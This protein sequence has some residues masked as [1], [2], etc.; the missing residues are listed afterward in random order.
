MSY[1]LINNY[2]EILVRTGGRLQGSQPRGQWQHAAGHVRSEAESVGGAVRPHSCAAAS[3]APA[4][5]PELHGQ[6]L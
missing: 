6:I 3:G 1:T 4:R 2:F 5:L